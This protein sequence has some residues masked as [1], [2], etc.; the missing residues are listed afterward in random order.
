MAFKKAPPPS[1]IPDSPGE[2]LRDLPRRKIPDVLPHQREIMRSYAASEMNEPDVALQLPTGS[3]KTLVGLMIGEWRRRKNQEKVVYLCTTRQLVNQVVEQAEE[4]YGLSVLGFTG[5]IRGFDPTAKAEYRNADRIAVTTYSSLFN[6]NPYFA[7]ADLLILDDV[8]SGEKYIS[9]LWSVS[10]ERTNPELAALHTALRNVLKP[11]LDPTSFAR[12]AGEL[13]GPA[14]RGWVDKMPTPEFVSIQKE[15][16]AVLDEH[17]AGKDIRHPWSMLREHL[18]ACQ[19]YF[20]SQQILIRPLI[21]PTWTHAP[22]SNPKQRV[23]MS[24]TLGAGGDLERMVGRHPIRR[25]EVPEGWDRQGVGR[26]FFIFPGMSLTE[27]QIATFR[28]KLMQLA[29]RSLVLVPS[30]KMRDQVAQ[31]VQENLGFPTFSAADIEESKK[32]FVGKQMAVA[33]VANRYDGI[34]FPGDECR[35]LFIE[36]LPKAVNLQERFLMARMGANILFNERIQTRVLQAI[37][38]C[39]RSLEDYSAVIVSGDELPDYLTEIRRRKYLHPELQ[40][41]LK[42][43]VDQSKDASLKD[44]LENFETFSANGREWEVVNQQIVMARVQAVRKPFPAMDDLDAIVKHEI[45][46]Q[47]RLWQGDYASSLA[48]AESVLGGLDASELRGYRALWHYLAGV[49]AWLG[50]QMGGILALSAKARKHF[51]EAKDAASGIPWLV[52]L[53]RYQSEG[54]TPAELD[55]GLM[56]QIERVEG[57]LE[58]LGTVHD[59]SFAKRE[60]EILEGLASGDKFEQAHRL[61]GEILG[62]QVG[63]V[64]TEGSPDPWWISGTL[65]LVFEDHAGAKEHSVIDVA[66]ARQVSS[67]PNWMRAN[68]EVSL[69]SRVLPVLVTPAKKVRSAAVP[70]LDGVGLWPVE[71]LRRFA[72]RTLVAIRELRKTFVEPGDLEWRAK[73]KELFE[74]NG[75]AARLLFA[76]LE[77]RPAS[78]LLEKIG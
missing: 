68:V 55:V 57:I 11:H 76:E 72:E 10:I 34:D 28:R 12:I 16:V 75:L 7:D 36:G 59:R 61:L 67:H 23:F 3:G 62:F 30:D 13:E 49:A 58:Q 24:A 60:K 53:S 77:S 78:K 18:P 54:I 45:E 39:T 47:T 42:F 74:Q 4:K 33:I 64:E 35:L 26:R 44:M 48:S 43:G 14:D 69:N 19:I 40:A 25:L 66:K 22:F 56:E 38:R 27:E 29:G 20:S 71:E 15:F 50:A 9:D 65:C 46:F 31:D 73:A 21:P 5:P 1:T 52:R 2:L 17:V 37:G 8:H 41:E 32:P 70:H 51:D 63:K 6:T